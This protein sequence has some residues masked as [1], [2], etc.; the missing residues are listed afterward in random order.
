M[1]KHELVPG[2]WRIFCEWK[3]VSLT[4]YLFAPFSVQ[5]GEVVQLAGDLEVPGSILAKIN[6]ICSVLLT[7]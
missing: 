1:P 5:G 6:Y 2:L 4:D 7:N 3:D